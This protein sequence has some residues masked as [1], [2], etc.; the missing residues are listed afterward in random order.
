MLAI[1]LFTLLFSCKSNQALVQDKTQ[2]RSIEFGNGG[3]FAGSLTKYKL[4]ESGLIEIQDKINGSFR[5]YNNIEEKVCQQI[6]NSIESLNLESKGIDDPGNLYY[7]LNV[8]DGE[9]SMKFNWGGVNQ[10]ADPAL[11]QYYKLLTSL[12]K[13]KNMATE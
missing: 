3:G 12:A 7:F 13:K 10:K 9:N 8:K 11:K 4:Y 2:M 1:G 6:F 5:S